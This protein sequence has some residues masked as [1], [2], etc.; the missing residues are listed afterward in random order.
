[1]ETPTSGL[2]CSKIFPLVVVVGLS[3][4]G[5]STAMDV[6]EDLCFF[7]VDGIPAGLAPKLVSLFCGQNQRDFRGLALAVDTRPSELTGQWTSVLNEFNDQ[8]FQPQIVFVEAAEEVLVR[9]YVTTRRP[10]PF[11]SGGKGRELG[12]TEA[13]AA[14][15]EL[16][17]SIR[18]QAMLIID[19]SCYS[20][21]NLRRIIQDKWGGSDGGGHVLRVHLIAFGFKYGTPSEVDLL[22]DLRFLPNPYFMDALKSLSGRDRAVSE[23]ILGAPPGSEFLNRLKEFLLYLLPLFEQEGRY[24]VTIGIGCTG[25]RHR[26]VAVAEAIEVALRQANYTVSLEH[27]HLE[28]G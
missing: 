11:S 25:G 21:H 4:A 24:L 6:F 2:S 26:S 20:I 3:G 22:F 13:I 5:K 9:R 23:Y 12:L 10:H 28:L 14:E 18:T 27:R 8:G 19:T 1:M 16:L 17:S 15:R 7:S